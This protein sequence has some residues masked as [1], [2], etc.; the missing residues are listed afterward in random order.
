MAIWKQ[1]C[2][3]VIM[4]GC[5]VLPSMIVEDEREESIIHIDLDKNVWASFALPPEVN[6]GGS[7]RFIHVLRR[8][9]TI[10]APDMND[11]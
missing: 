5:V 4:L 10:Y 8:K 3:G 11:S 1:K 6:V 2:V 7:L 9:A